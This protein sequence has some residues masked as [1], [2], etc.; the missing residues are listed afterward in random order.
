MRLQAE[1]PLGVVEDVL[2][3][4]FCIQA[5]TGLEEMPGCFQTGVFRQVLSCIDHF[6]LIYMCVSLKG[7]PF[8]EQ[9]TQSMPSGNGF[10]PLVSMQIYFPAMCSR[11][12]KVRSIRSEGS[13]P[14]KIT[15]FEG[16]A[17]IACKNIFI[18][19][20]DPF[21]VSGITKTAFQVASGEA[22]EN[23]RRTR[24]ETFSLE[25]VEYLVNL[26]HRLPCFLLIPELLLCSRWEAGRI[27]TGRYSRLSG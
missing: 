19:H 21:L 20:Q 3:H 9:V 24:M 26:S 16:K 11:S 14:V 23:G 5:G 17:E 6:D 7:N 1:V 10:V 15:T 8:G 4:L 18:R 22:D 12:I 2:Y 27:S 13:P 25:T